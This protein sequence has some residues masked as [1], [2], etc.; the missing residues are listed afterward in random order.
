MINFMKKKRTLIVLQIDQPVR[1]VVA[2]RFF[3][4]IYLLFFFSNKNKCKTKSS[5]RE[6]TV[7]VKYDI[8]QSLEY[9]IS[10]MENEA[11]IYKCPKIFYSKKTE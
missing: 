6:S 11:L 3:N 8:N 10:Q 2:H 1:N 4:F 7:A 9:F 5:T